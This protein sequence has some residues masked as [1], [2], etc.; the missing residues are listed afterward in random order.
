MGTIGR[1]RAGEAYTLTHNAAAQ[2]NANRVSGFFQIDEFEVSL[3][4]IPLP[5]G[6]VLLLGGLAA[7]VGVRRMK[8]RAGA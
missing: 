3:A 6:A 1:F 7:L 8:G 5:A 4:P 2:P